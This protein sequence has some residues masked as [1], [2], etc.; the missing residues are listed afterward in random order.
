MAP[1]RSR[2]KRHGSFSVSR[3]WWRGSAVVPLQFVAADGRPCVAAASSGGVRRTTRPALT[4][5]AGGASWSDVPG[6]T[7]TVGAPSRTLRK[8]QRAISHGGGL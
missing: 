4:Q 5:C 8:G 7:V 3:A 2:L 1:A 6:P